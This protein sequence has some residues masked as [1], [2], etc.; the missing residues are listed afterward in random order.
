MQS[1]SFLKQIHQ[2]Q[3]YKSLP[4]RCSAPRA[5]TGSRRAA[6]PVFNY[7]FN[8]LLKRKSTFFRRK[9]TFFHQE[10][11]S[12]LISSAF[13]HISRMT[14]VAPFPILTSFLTSCLTKNPSFL[15]QDSSF[16]NE[17]SDT[18]ATLKMPSAKSI[19]FDT[20][21]LVFQCTIPRFECTISHFYSP[22]PL[23][24]LSVFLSIGLKGCILGHFEYIN[25]RFEYINHRF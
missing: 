22:W 10:L 20:K 6:S 13:P 1:S 15:M 16:L 23:T 3:Q 19:I 25:H 9:S 12:F 11:T 8:I 21:F 14:C 2:F 17:N 18:F 7:K 4:R 24:V 5:R